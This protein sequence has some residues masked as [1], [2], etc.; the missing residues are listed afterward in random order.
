MEFGWALQALDGNGAV[1]SKGV[2]CKRTRLYFSARSSS[3]GLGDV[4]GSWAERILLLVRVEGEP[5]NAVCARAAPPRYPPLVFFAASRRRERPSRRST[6]AATVPSAGAREQG[7]VSWRSLWPP[8]P[9]LCVRGPPAMRTR[10]SY[11]YGSP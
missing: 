8:P 5:N 1:F 10:P 7:G 9:Q 6:A 11:A 3:I 2:A 4:L